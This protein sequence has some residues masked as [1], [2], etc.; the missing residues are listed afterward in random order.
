MGR[1]QG[2]G[3]RGRRPPNAGGVLAGRGRAPNA[4][5]ASG[6]EVDRTAV[7]SGPQRQ[8][9]GVGITAAPQPPANIGNVAISTTGIGKDYD[10]DVNG[11]GVS[12]SINRATGGAEIEFSVNGGHGKRNLPAATQNAI[13]TRLLQIVRSDAAGRPNG[14][15]YKVTAYKWD[16]SENAMQR[17]VAYQAIG[18]SRPA[19]G[20][21]GYQQ[22]GVVSGG[23]IR[24]DLEALKDAEK[25]YSA[26]ALQQVNSLWATAVDTFR[27][28]RNAARAARMA[29]QNNRIKTTG[30]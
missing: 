30:G 11:N 17:A 28:G 29:G 9:A 13:A 18:F 24:P 1:N 12:I 21:P 25:T 10:F 23:K 26:R 7:A 20:K 4:G 15:K 27:A 8:V 6:P 22:Y 14:F 19:T 16:S 2:S 3:G 5:V